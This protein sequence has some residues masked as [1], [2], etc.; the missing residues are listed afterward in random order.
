[1][2][3]SIIGQKK[4]S[5]PVIDEEIQP[6]ISRLEAPPTFSN[7]NISFNSNIETKNVQSTPPP[8]QTIAQ[9]TQIANKNDNVDGAA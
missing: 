3:L 8:S 6:S 4:K 7:I 9:V 1:M 2:Q 5:L